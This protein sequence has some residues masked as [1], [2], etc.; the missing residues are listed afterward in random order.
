MNTPLSRIES[1]LLISLCGAVL[2]ACLGPVLLQS[3]HYHAFADQRSWHALPYVMDVLS[4]VPFVIAGLWGL[5]G[6]WRL[7]EQTKGS[8]QW[9]LAAMFFAGLVLTG[10]CSSYYHWQPDDAGL[11]VDRLG[12][13]VAFSG[14]LGLAVAD[15]VSARASWVTAGTVLVLGAIAVLVWAHSGNLLP[16]VVLQGGGMLLIV[17]L[18]QRKP[19]GCAW[20]ISWDAVI[21]CY[22]LAKA[23]EFGDHAVFAWTQGWVSG[24]SL[25]HVIAALAAWPVIA[26]MH[27][28]AKANPSPSHA[29]RLA[30]PMRSLACK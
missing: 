5:R 14:L 11:T 29:R 21:V 8:A 9:F 3:T 25:K 20:S 17:A 1:G 27:N 6:W 15:R 7:P 2:L 12:M 23:L 30:Q 4:N 24:H 13:V 28:V 19:I 18:I 22:A 16:W 26:V 10:L